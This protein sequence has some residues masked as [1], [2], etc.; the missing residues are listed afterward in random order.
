MNFKRRK[1]SEFI[2]LIAGF[3]GRGVNKTKHIS[4]ITMIK[5]KNSNDHN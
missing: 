1:I 2:N 4:P 5:K 3:W